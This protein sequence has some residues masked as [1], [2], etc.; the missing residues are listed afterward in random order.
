MSRDRLALQIFEQA[1][2]LSSDGRVDL[3]NNAC[4]DDDQLRHGVEE[5]LAIHD[6]S[7][8]MYATNVV[9]EDSTGLIGPSARSNSPHRLAP[10]T[11]LID[12][13]EIKST[14]GAGGM[15]EVYRAVD[16]RL[17]RVVAVKVLNQE[18]LEQP[19]MTDRFE[20]E[21]KS[22]AALSHPNLVTI[23]DFTSHE[24]ITFAVMEFLDGQTL[25]NK[26]A[27][28]IDWQ[29]AVDYGTGIAAGLAAAHGRNIMHRDIKPENVIITQH[30]LSKIL[31]FGIARPENPSVDQDLTTEP[32]AQLGTAPYM[33]PEQTEG[34]AIGCSTDVFSFGTV[35][36]EALTGKNPFREANTFL[37][38]KRVN[39]ANPPNISE[40]NNDLPEQLSWLVT[41]MLQREP[42]QR[43]SAA[44][45][46]SVLSLLQLSKLLVGKD[47]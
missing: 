11:R 30:N 3:L 7:S 4:S 2:N 8:S 24:E 16:L 1:M 39:E 29:T 19:G 31:D 17:E 47:S 44:E 13:F 5:L 21:M 15:G 9:S 14:I 36:Y 43:P 40:L 42:A 20:R 6:E 26:I 33:S 41:S 18:V 28:G 23:H 37:T 34:N 22:V 25:R 35:L 32:T 27:V 38:M 12:R 45:A 46:E 10:G